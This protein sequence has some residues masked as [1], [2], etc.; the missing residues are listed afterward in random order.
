MTNVDKL[1]KE[2][3]KQL[4]EVFDLETLITDGANSIVPL[5]IDF[6]VYQDDKLLVKKYAV[7]IKPIKAY[8]LDNATR[9]GFKNPDTSFNAEIVKRGL[10][11]TDGETISPKTIDLLPAGV[12]AELADKICEISGIKQNKQDSKEL[13][14][15]MM[16]F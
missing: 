15:E 10:C 16:G 13:V 4:D 2:E 5:V 3:L 9:I 6:P 11:T 12:V 8:D 7:N 14:K 1:K